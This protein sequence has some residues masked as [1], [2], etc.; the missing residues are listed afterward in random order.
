VTES[1]LAWSLGL[2][3][4]F[5]LFLA[6]LR[7]LP[8]KL[9]PG[10]PFW[11]WCQLAVG[12]FAFSAFLIGGFVRER[13]RSPYTVYREIA[14]PEM[15]DREADRFLFYDKC[16]G[17]HRLAELERG[18][19]DWPATMAAERLR[20]GVELSEPQAA[21]LVRYLGETYR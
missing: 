16:L 14:K 8:P 6:L 20:A 10:H 17:C 13:S 4:L 1:R 11:A 21:R 5:A 7:W 12:L 15:V 3:I 9:K 19:R 2:V 18:G